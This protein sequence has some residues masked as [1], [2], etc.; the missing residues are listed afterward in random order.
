[1]DMKKSVKQTA[2]LLSINGKLKRTQV[3]AINDVLDGHDLLVVAPISFGKSA[4][5]QIPSIIKGGLTI[6]LVPTL[7]LLHDQTDRLQQLGISV[8]TLASD[9]IS[10]DNADIQ[11]AIRKHGYLLLY[12]T[13]EPLW[14][15]DLSDFSVTCL[16][17]DECHCVL[18]IS[19][20][21]S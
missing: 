15:L 16:V 6:V 12:T 20:S 7:S 10:W 1:M 19:S 18:R 3:E 21:N 14:K 9:C 5:F 4:I 17:V 8:G 2:K 11:A 13:P